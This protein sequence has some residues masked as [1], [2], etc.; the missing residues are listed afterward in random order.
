MQRYFFKK[1]IARNL[2]P[3]FWTWG[4]IVSKV[5]S[6]VRKAFEKSQRRRSHWAMTLATFA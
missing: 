1:K 3:V 6:N 4:K 5:L 2:F